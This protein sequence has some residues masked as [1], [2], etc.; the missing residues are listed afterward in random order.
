M[1]WAIA[2]GVEIAS[3]GC[4]IWTNDWYDE[5][6]PWTN[7]ESI[8]LAR[9]PRGGDFAGKLEDIALK[10]DF[11]YAPNTFSVHDIH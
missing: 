5:F 7:G 10:M 11:T 2:S 1:P 4:P 8:I 9:Y 6:E 3:K